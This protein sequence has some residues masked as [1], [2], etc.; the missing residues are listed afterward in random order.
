MYSYTSLP[1]IEFFTLDAYAQDSQH[2]TDFDPDMLTD[3][4]LSTGYY[5]ICCMVMR[6]TF[7]LKA[8]V[9]FW[10]NLQV[11]TSIDP[12]E[13]DF[14]VYYYVQLADTVK[15]ILKDIFICIKEQYSDQGESK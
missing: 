8:R 6:L 1:C 7:I 15:Y 4:E 14:G 13:R 11:M 9:A 10:A 3:E 12:K 5:T 2:H